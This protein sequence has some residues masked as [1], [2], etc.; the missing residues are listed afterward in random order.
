MVWRFAT[1]PGIPEFPEFL[2]C[3][4]V[5]GVLLALGGVV[6]HIHAS[7]HIGA[8]PILLEIGKGILQQLSGKEVTVEFNAKSGTS[9][10]AQFA[11]E[12]D[13]AG[14]SVCGRKRFRV[15]QNSE[16]I[17]FAMDVAGRDIAN[18]KAFLAINTDVTNSA[19]SSGAGDLID[20]LY[21]RLRVSDPS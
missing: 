17:V 6:L 15:G 4:C 11:I 1:E 3:V 8:D 18:S 12:C 21:V 14:D 16:K 9:S 13:I 20:I 7:F 2:E 19:T 5:W 10:P